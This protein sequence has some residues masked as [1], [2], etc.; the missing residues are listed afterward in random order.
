MAELSAI[1]GSDRATAH[2]YFDDPEIIDYI[3]RAQPLGSPGTWRHLRRLPPR[4][5]PSTDQH[6]NKISHHAAASC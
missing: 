5:L 4:T 3:L 6:R 2:R 1:A